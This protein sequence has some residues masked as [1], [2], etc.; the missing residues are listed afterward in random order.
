V[1]AA[2]RVAEDDADYA[3]LWVGHSSGQGADEDVLTVA[4]THDP[5]QHE[6]EI[7]EVSG[8][9][10]CLTSLDY[11]YAELLRTR[12]ELSDGGAARLGLQMTWSD[13]DVMHNQVVLGAVV[14]DSSM[15]AELDST[16]G[17]GLV[18]VEAALQPV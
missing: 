2:M 7:R 10:L 8:G 13:V 16:S 9:P 3:G 17:P 18:R 12:H 4:F 6:T 15:Q 11:T 14:S 1:V 5:T